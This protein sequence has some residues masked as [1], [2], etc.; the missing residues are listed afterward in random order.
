ML[1]STAIDAFLRAK[2]AK[3]LAKD[4]L[5]WY[6][7]ILAAFQH[8][9]PVVTV[10]PEEI[11]TFLLSCHAGDERRHGYYRA[12]RAFYR[13]LERRYGI[14]NPMRYVEAPKRS[15][16][17]PKPITPVDLAQLLAYCHPLKIKVAISALA[18]TGARVGEL[19]NLTSDDLAETPWGYIATVHGKTGARQ[20]PISYETYH[21][22]MVNLPL[23]Y[24]RQRL[25][26][27]IALAFRQAGV[28]GTAHSL[29]HTFATLWEGDELVL[30]RIMGHAHLE[31]TKL[32]RNLRLR[33]LSEQH[34]RFSPLRMVQSLTKDMFPVL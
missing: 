20:V 2:E 15:H 3:G 1:T 24:S 13:F 4:S 29:R 19:A 21:A 18:D 31:T 7:G 12:L 26:R 10:G 9:V 30:Q 27:L 6:R 34:H 33:I 17:L 8:Q 28:K 23:G 5:R 32:Y 22:L 16:K 25:S 11:D 14:P